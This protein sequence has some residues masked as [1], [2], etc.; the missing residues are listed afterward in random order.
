MQIMEEKEIKIV[1]I[2]KNFFF[3]QCIKKSLK[4]ILGFNKKFGPEEVADVLI[5]YKKLSALKYSISLNKGINKSTIVFAE[6][7]NELELKYL[8][9]QK[10]RYK[11]KLVIHHGFSHPNE[12]YNPK[13]LNDVDYILVPSEWVKE[14]F[15]SE[16][17]TLNFKTMSFPW[18]CYEY[19]IN[20]KNAPK[21]K[22]VKCIIYDKSEGFDSD[23]DYFDLIR[24]LTDIL[25]QY[26]ITVTI[27]KYK[28]YKNEEYLDLLADSDMMIYLSNQETQGL[29]QMQ[30]WRNNIPTITFDRGFAKWSDVICP[31][32][33]VPYYNK[34]VGEKFD[35][36]RSFETVLNKFIENYDTY[37]PQKYYEENFSYKAIFPKLDKLFFNILESE[38]INY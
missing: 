33:S 20:Q 10:Q 36:I 6:G 1:L 14:L 12:L 4:S 11:F 3:K 8:I 27:I 7:L 9:K 28:H 21:E 13:I 25:Q 22:L 37:K 35:E 5:Q 24:K 32:S 38:N 26:G 16:D 29:A 15:I 23:N 17:N 18:P 31:G 19:R 34:L 2:T 30:A